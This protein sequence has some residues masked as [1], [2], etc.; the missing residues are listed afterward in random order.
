[1]QINHWAHKKE[2]ITG[3]LD[4]IGMKTIWVR[5]GY[6]RYQNMDDESKSPDFIV[7][8]IDEI[9][10]AIRGLWTVSFTLKEF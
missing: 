9:I 8:H 4:N 5:Q 1:M 3:V 7:D 6:A 10:R 2:L